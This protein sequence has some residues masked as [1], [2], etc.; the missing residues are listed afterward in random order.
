MVGAGNEAHVIGYG[1]DAAVSERIDGVWRHRVT[2]TDGKLPELAAIPV[3]M[4]LYTAV[5]KYRAVLALHA[6]SRV[7]LVVATPW[8][9]ESLV[10][11]LDPRL[12]VVTSLVTSVKFMTDT[13]LLTGE[14]WLTM[15]RLEQAVI[16]RSRYFVAS[17]T[18]IVSDTE[19][20]FGVRLPAVTPTPFGT[21]D[22]AQAVTRAERSG[23]V[24]DVVVLCVGR[25]EPRKGADVLLAAAER[26]AGDVGNVVYVFVGEGDWDAPRSRVEQDARLRDHVLFLGW[27]D[28]RRL[29]ELYAGADIVCVPSHYESFGLVL[30]EAMMFGKPIVASA[31]GGMPGV[32]E[33]GG[34]ALLVPPG[35]RDRLA[36]CL[37]QLIGNPSLRRELRPTLPG[38]IRGA[39]HDRT[40]GGT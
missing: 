5:A 38:A 24:E 25:Y 3:A 10:C 37:H 40:D 27:V 12:T 9:G 7:D 2:V 14:P 15:G 6:R 18:A 32:V 34:N 28:D 23:S 36:A 4:D 35:D 11:L 8:P 31:V 13:G 33:E 21:A 29:W 19:A 16:A 20:T 39:L 22:C 30:T 17:S 26:L 1:E